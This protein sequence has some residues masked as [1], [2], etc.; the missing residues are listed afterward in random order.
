MRRS[1]VLAVLALPAAVLALPAGAAQRPTVV[2]TPLL[3]GELSQVSLAGTS[4][5]SKAGQVVIVLAKECSFTHY[6][7]VGATRTITGGSWIHS[8]TVSMNTSYRV[9]TRG[10]YSRPIVVR[11]RAVVSLSRRPG[12][13][14]FEA[15]VH[16]GSPLLG[17]RIRL[18]RY[19]RSGWVLVS[20]AK[21]RRHVIFGRVE[22]TFRV[23]QQGLELRAVVPAQRARPC[24]VAG[25]SKLVRS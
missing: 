2:A 8:T 1:L 18:E 17:K 4:G 14:I 13:R 24:F 9:R 3:V 21:L 19:T 11:K 12:T 6:R 16:G 7:V 25:A 20:Q 23:L 15:A 10:V 5:S 22:A